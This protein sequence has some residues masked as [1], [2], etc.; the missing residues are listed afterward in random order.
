VKDGVPIAVR[1]GVNEGDG[2]PV[3]VACAVAVAGNVMANVS[4]VPVD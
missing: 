3:T 2:V 1:A 4:S